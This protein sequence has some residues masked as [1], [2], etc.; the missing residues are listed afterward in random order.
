MN[1]MKETDKIDILSLQEEAKS[2]QVAGI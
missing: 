1:P 2:P